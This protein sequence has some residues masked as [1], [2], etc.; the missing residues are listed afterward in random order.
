VKVIHKHRLH[1]ADSVRRFQR[2]V[3]ALAQLNHPNI[4]KA[5]DAGQVNDVY[6]LVMEF[7]AGTDLSRRVR[8]QGPLPVAEACE[9][10]RQAALGLQHAFEKGM[11]HRDIKP[12]NLLLTTQSPAVVKILDMG[13]ARLEDVSGIDSSDTLTESGVVLGTPDYVSPEQIGD[14]R[15]ADIRSDLYSLG[16]T[17]YQLLTGQPP[18]PGVTI[19]LKLLLHQS[20]EPIPLE[21]INEEIPPEV[22]EVV[23]KLMAKQPH[24]RFQTPRELVIALGELLRSRRVQ[25]PDPLANIHAD[26]GVIPPPPRPR[27][28]GS[29]RWWAVAGAALLGVVTVVAALFFHQ[30]KPPQA[31]SPIV[32]APPPAESVRLPWHP[33]ELVRILGD[34]RGRHWGK[35]NGVAWSLDGRFIVSAGDD[36][37][38][39]WDSATLREKQF[40]PRPSPVIGIGFTDD[41]T[42]WS[43]DGGKIIEWQFRGEHPPVEKRSRNGDAT[44]FSRDGRFALSSWSD[45]V[46]TDLKTNAILHKIPVGAQVGGAFSPDGKLAAWATDLNGGI[47][48]WELEKKKILNNFKKSE[49]CVRHL[50]FSPNRI[51]PRKP[52]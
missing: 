21:S 24:H 44:C 52:T 38:R 10:I 37:I 9:F 26:S 3:R 17:F 18:F 49:V 40:V 32:P 15:N 16:C 13:L 43:S 39:I 22:A 14:P 31:T 12:S 33:R 50:A 35:V 51:A 29:K 36:G 48:L 2:E 5:F 41:G 34:K 28:R 47:E 11:V 8:D 45:V 42:L 46:L 4:V 19:G 30:P 1:N 27:S 25:R 23:R 7:V 6:F 20:E